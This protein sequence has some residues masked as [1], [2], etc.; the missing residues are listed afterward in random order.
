[1]GVY[2][3]DI[4]EAELDLKILTYM[5]ENKPTMWWVE[6]ESRISLAYQTYIKT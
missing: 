6:F 3:N 5:G 4:T 2:Y 1:M